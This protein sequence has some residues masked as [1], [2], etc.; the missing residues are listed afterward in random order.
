LL[1]IAA[2]ITGKASAAD[3]NYAYKQIIVAF[4]FQIAISGFFAYDYGNNYSPQP[5]E[6]FTTSL[7]LVYIMLLYLN[8]SNKIR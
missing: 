3:I 7:A 4:L 8:L 1:T 6:T 2:N 5:F